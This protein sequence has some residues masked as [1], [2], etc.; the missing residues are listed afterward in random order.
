LLALLVGAVP[1]ARASGAEPMT[2]Y[3]YERP[4]FS[5]TDK[6][7]GV[8]GLI[9]E[10]TRAAFGHVGIP[11]TFEQTSIKRVLEL[12]RDDAAPV[13]SPGWYRTADRMRFAKFT[14]PIY[15]DK[16]PIGI[17]SKSLPVPPGTRIADLLAGDARL[18]VNDGFTYGHY[19]DP[20]IARKDPS[21]VIHLPR[22][23][24]GAID[25]VLAG[26]ADLAL[27][28]EEDAASYAPNG[29]GG[30]DY[31]ILHFPDIP[32]GEARYIICSHSV[33]DAVIDQLNEAIDGRS[34]PPAAGGVDR[35]SP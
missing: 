13:C 11:I 25:L 32:A 10:P 19:L 20:L 23:L 3:Y 4:P 18:V 7:G 14:D 26:R 35:L 12:V 22:P 2:I 27:V 24:H 16:P 15:R 34:G 28:T 29:V 9:I 33:A 31:P 8:S 30:P 6:D 1:F 21:Q 17:A 5:V